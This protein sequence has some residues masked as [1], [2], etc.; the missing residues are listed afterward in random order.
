MRVRTIGCLG[1]AL[2]LAGTMLAAQDARAA[3]PPQPCVELNLADLDYETSMRTGT[4]PR[5]DVPD[6]PVDAGVCFVLPE[7]AG[8]TIVVGSGGAGVA[9][10]V[11]DAEGNAVCQE[12]GSLIYGAT[13]CV[14]EGIA[15]FTVLVFGVDIS[16]SPRPYALQTF[17]LGGADACPSHA[18]TGFGAATGRFRHSWPADGVHCW[19][20]QLPDGPLLVRD[21]DPVILDGEFAEVC[22]PG[23]SDDFSSPGWRR[24]DVEAGPGFVLVPAFG[25]SYEPPA[26]RDVDLAVFDGSAD[27]G[28]HAVDTAWSSP[29]ETVALGNGVV[30]CLTVGAP[31]ATPWV[32]QAR[33][34]DLDYGPSQAL[35]LDR[36]GEQ[37][38]QEATEQ[39]AR[40]ACAPVGGAPYRILVSADSTP[41]D[42]DAA[43][44]MLGPTAGCP[45]VE[46]APWGTPPTSGDD[47]GFGCRRVLLDG[48][49]LHARPGAWM[50]DDAA[51]EV[52]R[53]PAC[54]LPTGPVTLVDEIIDATFEAV[55]YDLASTEGC[56]RPD[57]PWEA[58][59]YPVALDTGYCAILDGVAGQPVG[60]LQSSDGRPG[61]SWRSLDSAGSVT[62]A[63]YV[64]AG[65][66]P[67]CIPESTGPIRM[68]SFS[69]DYE[70]ATENALATFGAADLADCVI[71]TRGDTRVITLG[72]YES[73]CLRLEG[74]R[75][76]GDIL[77]VTTDAEHGV[78][79]GEVG[80][81]EHKCSIGTVTITA[82]APREVWCARM[83]SSSD[84]TAP[85]SFSI[86]PIFGAS[87]RSRVAL[88]WV[89]RPRL[90]VTQRPSFRRQPRA[91]TTARVRPGSWTGV[92][93]IRFTYRWKVGGTVVRGA[94]EPQLHLKK[95]WAG[96]RIEVLVTAHSRGSL[97]ERRTASTGSQRIRR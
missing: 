15:P 62:D 80:T 28:C 35:V 54:P 77:R 14:L 1:A 92:R 58:I 29:S 2:L 88:E 52:C 12:P 56:L 44:R 78:A 85:D 41:G 9:T 67:Y 49:R 90:Q 53:D 69:E 63:C 66:K 36:D 60:L 34:S 94:Q 82:P 45:E 7:A 84:V 55:V 38:C 91:G 87:A 50:L 40:F 86:L 64:G 73:G 13:H 11:I 42:Y 74:L 24:C 81:P 30:Q 33:R 97:P 23:E 26:P 37:V 32:Y 39:G 68:V 17:T 8:S 16:T 18:L 46:V 70:Y 48:R 3:A 31:D 25:S 5:N 95:G 79:L 76:Q 96:R 20:V 75:E 27:T 6:D 61:R 47:S 59:V 93:P 10:R 71:L 89:A 19:S 83:P 72:R 43:V 57:E 51:R 4:L 65:M 21:A 22:S